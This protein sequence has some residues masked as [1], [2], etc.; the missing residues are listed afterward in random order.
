MRNSSTHLKTSVTCLPHSHRE[1][2]KPSALATAPSPYYRPLNHK[3]S[4]CSYFL[5]LRV[6]ISM[7]ISS[8]LTN[9]CRCRHVT[10]LSLMANFNWVRHRGM[11]EELSTFIVNHV[12]RLAP[13]VVMT[14]KSD[15]LVYCK[16]KHSTAIRLVT[17][18]ET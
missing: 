18:E 8:V 6:L 9:V 4:E 13:I 5:R 11:L 16:H 3:V 17:H 7:Y 2:L 12:V 1:Y 14:A 10:N 15:S